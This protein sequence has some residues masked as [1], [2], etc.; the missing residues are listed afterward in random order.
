M[1][2]NIATK[3]NMAALLRLALNLVIPR[4]PGSTPNTSAV[5]CTCAAVG[6]D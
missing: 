3:Q 5:A 6:S 1:D 2:L 4:V